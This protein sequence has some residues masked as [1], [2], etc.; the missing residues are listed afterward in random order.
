MN[1][2]SII[3]DGQEAYVG[4]CIIDKHDNLMYN[5]TYLGIGTKAV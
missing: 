1:A 2:T 3:K 4:E 5:N